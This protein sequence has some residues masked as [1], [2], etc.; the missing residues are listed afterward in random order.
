M[1]DVPRSISD[2]RN[3]VGPV[4]GST[5]PEVGR[6][7]RRRVCW[8]YPSLLVAAALVL[9]LINLAR[10]DHLTSDQMSVATMAL[11]K[12]DPEMFASSM[13][14]ANERHYSWYLPSYRVLITGLC[15]LTG[16]PQTAY[17]L[18]MLLTTLGMMLTVFYL[19]VGLGVDP[20]LGFLGAILA[21]LP[22]L[23]VGETLWGAGIM[24]TALPRTFF[25]IGFPLIVLLLF[26]KAFKGW[27]VPVAFLGVGLLANI[28]PQSG[29]FATCI[30]GL[31]VLVV[32]RFR[33][34]AWV[35]S[36]C[37]GVCALV[38]V[39]PFF[40]ASAG[41]R[42]RSATPLTP[43]HGLPEMSR[44]MDQVGATVTDLLTRNIGSR[45]IVLCACVLPMLLAVILCTRM[46]SMRKNRHFKLSV[47]ATAAVVAFCI[48]APFMRNILRTVETGWLNIGITRI[49]Y[50]RAT[51][52]IHFFSVLAVVLCLA[53]T[54]AMKSF[55][56]K[57]R[58][59][60]LIGLTLVPVLASV[61]GLEMVFRT[62]F[63]PF[64]QVAG[65]A[66]KTPKGTRFLVHPYGAI[67][68]RLW[69]R[70]PVP[71][72]AHDVQFFFVKYPD[73]QDK[74]LKL[75]ED[76]ASWYAEARWDALL[77]FAQQENI[78]YVVGPSGMRSIMRPVFQPRQG[79]WVFAAPLG[80][81]KGGDKMNSS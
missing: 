2:V 75:S 65:W 45:L 29:M 33:L 76:I 48:V 67:A 57:L 53:E 40:V 37:G 17:W 26:R 10:L 64:E 19:F 70:R 51:R 14:Y 30:L 16:S 12:L 77:D 78:P 50:L 47:Y 22:R 69:S 1:Q 54:T 81:Q 13:L 34:R 52:F 56:A 35:F 25:G 9:G 80:R 49:V 20:R 27:S 8:V 61:C 74:A 32:H 6:S 71:I 68:F 46:A 18:L 62:R 58:K 63:H 24:E 31:L 5:S 4:E 43:E 36:V 15:R 60:V 3:D 23:S 59:A 73:V 79:P 7:W 72:A 21:S 39:M 38:G 42:P 28:H 66:A 41:W 55:R 44:L 11:Q